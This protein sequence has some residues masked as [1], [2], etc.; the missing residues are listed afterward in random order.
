MGGMMSELDDRDP[1][2]TGPRT[3]RTER[4]LLAMLNSAS[5][6]L[7]RAIERAERAEARIAELEDKLRIIASYEGRDEAALVC[8]GLAKTALWKGE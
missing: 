1:C 2:K 7:C 5:T 4:D 3:T 8:K 6:D